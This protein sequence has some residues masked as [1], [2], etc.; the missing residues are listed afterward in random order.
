M[1]IVARTFYAV[2]RRVRRR[3]APA[4]AL[5]R[6]RGVDVEKDRPVG[7][8]SL[9][10]K[11]VCLADNVERKPTPIPLVCERRIAEPVGNNPRSCF[12]RGTDDVPNELSAR[13][14]EKKKLTVE[15]LMA[16]FEQVSGSEFDSDKALLSK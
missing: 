15:D 6:C 13:G 10:G 5:T 9:A 7:L 8:Q 1:E 4:H 14:E 11:I 16:K 12:K 2:C 3:L